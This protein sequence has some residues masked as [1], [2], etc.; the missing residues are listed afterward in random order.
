M[1]PI[2]TLV[3]AAS[4]LALGMSTT[5][6]MNQAEAANSG[7]SEYVEYVNVTLF[8]NAPVININNIAGDKHINSL[9]LKVQETN[10]EYTVCHLCYV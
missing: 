6:M 2:K 7:S 8:G 10:I 9:N 4:V 3:L 5:A 1:K